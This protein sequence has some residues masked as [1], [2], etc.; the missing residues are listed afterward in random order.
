[1]ANFYYNQND[2]SWYSDAAYTTAA[3][4]Y[5]ITSGDAVIGDISGSRTWLSFKDLT[6]VDFTD[7]TN[8]DN[9]DLQ[10]S[11]LSGVDFSH[12]TSFSNA[13]KRPQW[14]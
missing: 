10:Q 3:D 11:N 9:T 12:I 2:D 7:V 14:W 5:T 13:N 6:G 4:L 8:L 1:M